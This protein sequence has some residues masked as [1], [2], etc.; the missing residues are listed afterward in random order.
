[1]FS[2]FPP[3]PG[4]M[5]YYLLELKMLKKSGSKAKVYWH[6]NVPVTM[7]T[8]PL[9]PNNATQSHPPLTATLSNA[10]VSRNVGV[11]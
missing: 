10:N 8:I 3:S 11:S 2:I 6:V 1:M 7:G 4:I 9:N 5:V